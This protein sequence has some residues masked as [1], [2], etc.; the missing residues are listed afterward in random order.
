LAAGIV[1]CLRSPVFDPVG[2]QLGLFV[3]DDDQSFTAD[4]FLMGV[5]VSGRW[6]I[7]MY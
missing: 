5:P 7:S 2:E 4:P 1:L 6:Q 3:V